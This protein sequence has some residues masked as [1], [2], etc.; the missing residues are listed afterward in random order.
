MTDEK[1]LTPKQE[2]FCQKYIELGNASEAYRQSYDAE[3]MLDK[4][5]WEEASRT[6]ADHKVAA[7]IV[8][9]QEEHRE[10]H[11]VTVDSLTAELQESRLLATND[12]QHSAA[13]AATMGKAKLHGHLVEKSEVSGPN[14]TPFTPTITVTADAVKSIVQQVRDEF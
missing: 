4:T 11:R 5:I 3:N 10:R 9:L 1:Q 14:G 12:K 8:H 13:I 6:L 7:R 2:A